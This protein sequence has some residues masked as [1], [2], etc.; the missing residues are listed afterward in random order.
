M[1][2]RGGLDAQ[3]TA[4]GQNGGYDQHLVPCFTTLCVCQTE[5]VIATTSQGSS[6]MTALPVLQPRFKT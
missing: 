3:S 2:E 5:S 1:G 6:T 4:T